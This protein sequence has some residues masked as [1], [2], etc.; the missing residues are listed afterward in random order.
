M[1]QQWRHGVFLGRSASSDQNYVG[2]L[3][4]SVVRARAIVRLIPEARWDARK[5]LA[6]TTDPMTENTHM[7]DA[8]EN[9]KDTVVEDVEPGE[10]GDEP[11]RK[12]VR[13]TLQD[14]ST[15]GFSV[16]CP[17]CACYRAGA[18]QRAEFHKHTEACRARIYDSL[19]K[20]GSN[21]MM[22][23]DVERTKTHVVKHAE[24]AAASSWEASHS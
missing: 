1:D 14:L 5:V 23:A 17:R 6:V 18:P 22:F 4:G 20:A 15:H 11:Q 2:L 10:P 13:I 7:M 8:L 24:Q 16:D 9:T 19:R 3:N 12:R 21:K